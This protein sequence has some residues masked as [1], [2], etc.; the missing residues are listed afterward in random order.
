M[1]RR[2]SGRINSAYII[3]PKQ[4]NLFGKRADWL[5][6]NSTPEEIKPVLQQ[7]LQHIQE[8]EKKKDQIDALIEKQAKKNTQAVLL[9]SI[10]GVGWFTAYLVIVFIDEI[11]R[12]PSPEQLVSYVGLAPSIYQSGNTTHFGHISK[13]GRSELRWALGQCSWIAVR[14]TNKFRKKYLKIKRKHGKKKA[15]TAVARKM[16]TVMY[17]MLKRNEVFNENA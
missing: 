5:E 11:K 6:K 14:K 13:H 3:K 8:L 4:K 15:I 16:L 17:Y 1:N 9:Q 2:I 7:S 10:P 12:F